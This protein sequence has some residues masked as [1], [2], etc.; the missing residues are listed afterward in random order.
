MQETPSAEQTHYEKA[1]IVEAI[2]DLRV[3]PTE[4]MSVDD[5]KAIHLQISEQYPTCEN[6]YWGSGEINVATPGAEAETRTDHGHS[7]FLYQDANR[8]QTLQARLDGFT[9]SVFNPYD[10]WE[11]FRDEARRLWN[12]YRAHCQLI[13]VTRVAL[14]YINRIDIPGDEV[15]MKDYFQTYPHVSQKYTHQNVNGLFMQLQM[16]QP[17]LD[18]LLILNQA[19]V[20]PQRE[21][22]ISIMLDLDLSK[23]A[24]QLFEPV[25]DD[26]PIW[27]LLEKFRVRKNEVFNASI[28]DKVREIIR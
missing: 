12:I 25:D 9:F 17:D 14:R 26:A 11:T 28:T 6:F 5:L 8:K 4:A 27:D 21:H 16:K 24:P 15:E 2:I 23:A 18:S 10:R 20:E 1:P 19:G 13:N 7:G 22:T 3:T